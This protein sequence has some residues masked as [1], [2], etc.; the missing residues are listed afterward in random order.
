[1]RKT[2]S[3][4]NA[5]AIAAFSRRAVV[6]VVAEGLLDDDPRPAAAPRR[7]ADV[8]DDLLEDARGDREV[9]DAVPTACRAPG[10]DRR[11]ARRAAPSSRRR[12]TRPARSGCPAASWSQ[13]SSSQSSR[14]WAWTASRILAWKSSVVISLRA[15]PTTA[16]RSGQEVAHGERVEGG[17]ELALRQVAGGAEDRERAG[18]GRALAL[19]SFEQRVLGGD[20]HVS[21]LLHR[22]AR[23][24]RCEARRSPWPRTTRPGARRSAR[25][26]PPR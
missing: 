15:T 2:S 14:Q 3:S 4:V 1:M 10:R 12:R 26:A 24:T 20:R 13:T 8:L 17:E 5:F 11:A 18:L 9:E 16:N 6:E 22:R 21:R 23:R 7:V 19:E 25:R